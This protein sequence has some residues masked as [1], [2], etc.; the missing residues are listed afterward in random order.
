MAR[1]LIVEKGAADRTKWDISGLIRKHPGLAGGGRVV[2]RTRGRCTP[3]ASGAGGRRLFVRIDDLVGEAHR[4][5]TQN[6][7]GQCHH[8]EGNGDAADAE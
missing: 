5:E 8:D 7:D 1:E 6:L 2:T 4:Q 3:A